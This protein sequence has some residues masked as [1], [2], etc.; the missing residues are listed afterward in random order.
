M[1]A[2]NTKKRMMSS[3]TRRRIP[4]TAVP[5]FAETSAPSAKGRRAMIPTI[6]MREIP[7]PIP[8]SVILSPSHITNIVPP[9]RITV[10]TRLNQKF[11]QPS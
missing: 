7:L 10:E 2:T 1:A 5:H 4:P 6:M 3:T 8:R 11:D 9:M